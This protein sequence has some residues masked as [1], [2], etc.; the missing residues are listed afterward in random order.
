MSRHITLDLQAEVT[1]LS[2]QPFVGIHN[3][4]QAWG[5][6]HRVLRQLG[7]SFPLNV[8]KLRDLLLTNEIKQK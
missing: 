7:C 3:F 8:G 4:C 2:Q 1:N 6:H 5:G